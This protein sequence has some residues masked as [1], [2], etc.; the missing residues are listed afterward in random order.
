MEESAAKIRQRAQAEESRQNEIRHA[1]D[2]RRHMVKAEIRPSIGDIMADED[3]R[4]PDPNGLLPV[5][6]ETLTKF[7]RA[8]PDDHP[9]RA[10]IDSLVEYTRKLL[11]EKMQFCRAA[12]AV[13]KSAELLEELRV[14]VKYQQFDLEATRR[15]NAALRALL[16]EHGIDP[17]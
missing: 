13:E 5:V 6:N 8:F 1:I 12:A 14:I 10:A 15:E 9:L 4:P 7:R 17:N 2:I 16:S 3:N 11:V